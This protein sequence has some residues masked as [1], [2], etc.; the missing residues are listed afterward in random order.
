MGRDPDT[1]DLALVQRSETWDQVRM[2][3]LLDSLLSGNPI[4]A[5]LLCRVRQRSRSIHVDGSGA[6]HV[7]D[8][9]ALS[10]RAT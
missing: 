10:A 8:A 3:H 7:R 4:G 9:D 6:R 5:I 2:R 1:W